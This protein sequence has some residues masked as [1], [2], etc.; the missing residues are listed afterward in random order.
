[1]KKKFHEKI[2]TKYF[3]TPQLRE[4]QAHWFP[5]KTWV[6]S[7]LFHFNKRLHNFL[8]QLGTVVFSKHY[9]DGI[10]QCICWGPLSVADQYIFAVLVSIYSSRL[11]LHRQHSLTGS[12]VDNMENIQYHQT[13][14]LM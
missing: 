10:K 7:T 1:M 12:L 13:Y 6:T 4:P 9:S 3:L 14:P 8:K 5:M 2:K 11:W